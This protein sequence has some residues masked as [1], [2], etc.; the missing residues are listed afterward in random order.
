M[1][2][3]V[4]GALI[5]GADLGEP[6]DAVWHHASTSFD[7]EEVAFHYTSTP[8]GVW[9][10]A[11]PSMLSSPDDEMVVARIAKVL[12]GESLSKGSG[13][14]WIDIP[15]IVGM[16]FV[17]K[18]DIENRRIHTRVMEKDQ[19]A[20]QLYAISLP[21]IEV[22]WQGDGVDITR[23]NLSRIELQHM[24]FSGVMWAGFVG[25]GASLLFL[26]Y[27]V[28]L[29]QYGQSTMIQE[30]LESQTQTIDHSVA[31]INASRAT[32]S[33]SV[34]MSDLNDITNL[35][36]KFDGKI[37]YYTWDKGNTRWGLTV[38][39][40]ASVPGN[41]PAGVTLERNGDSVLVK[42]N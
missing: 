39:I 18:I 12:P 22:D 4:I 8:Q 41:F 6:K 27:Q 34:A 5:P 14:Y 19:D 28:V 1:F 17:V 36:F 30:V 11:F 33:M 2:D 3:R 10:L 40:W 25:L 7:Q 42:K 37:E 24:I 38:P 16:I 21:V 20:L 29:N 23:Y 35:A 9:Y 13:V 15:H 31:M 26:F 32:N